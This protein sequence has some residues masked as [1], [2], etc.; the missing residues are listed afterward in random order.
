MKTLSPYSRARHA[1]SYIP[2]IAYLSGFMVLLLLMN[3]YFLTPATAAARDATPEGKRKLQAVAWLMLS[4]TL[5]YLLIGLMLTF[6]IGRFFF[7]RPTNP[8]VRTPHVDIWAEAG[9]R[10]DEKDA[11][12]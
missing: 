9:K 7:P 3:H 2:V 6:R 1:L 5:V 11:E 8:R 10:L 12:E 4:V